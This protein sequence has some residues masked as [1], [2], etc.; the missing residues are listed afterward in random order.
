MCAIAADNVLGRNNLHLLRLLFLLAAQREGESDSSQRISP[1][2]EREAKGDELKRLLLRSRDKG[3]AE[4]S[5]AGLSDLGKAIGV[6]LLLRKVAEGDLDRV[7][8]RIVEER[9]VDFKCLGN[10]AALNR[11]GALG[12]FL[13]NGWICKDEK[14]TMRHD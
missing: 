13:R 5:T 8:V 7:R 6:G 12:V 1:R 9:L 11:D 14:E 3:R 4:Q 10:D 2:R